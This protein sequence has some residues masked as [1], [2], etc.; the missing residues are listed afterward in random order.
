MSNFHIFEDPIAADTQPAS[1]SLPNPPNPPLSV[2]SCVYCLHEKASTEFSPDELL[3]ATSIPLRDATNE[4]NIG[5]KKNLKRKKN[6]PTCIVCREKQKRRNQ[7]RRAKADEVKQWERIPWK[8]IIR[9]IEDG[10]CF[11]LFILIIARF[12]L[13]NFLFL[14]F[15]G[16]SHL[17][18]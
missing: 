8:E 16:N 2:H 11:Y 4:Q 3:L 15:F 6:G 14:I 1:N 9:M 7:A 5:Q 12:H 17:M 13:N 10:F 18:L